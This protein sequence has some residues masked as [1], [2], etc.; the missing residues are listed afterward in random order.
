[1]RDRPLHATLLPTG[2]RLLALLADALDGG[3]AVLPLDPA[4]P[5]HRL[6]H[7]LDVLRP[8]RLVT[9]D[10]ARPLT[11]GVPVEGDTAVVIATSGS[12]GERKAVEL[13]A[14][15]LRFSGQAALRRLRAASDDRW[16]CCLPTHHIAGLQVLVRSLMLGREPVL[17]R[18]FGVDA[19][20][21]SGC[22]FV[23]LVPTMLRRILDAGGDVSAFR[24]ILLGGSSVPPGLVE[25]ARA[26]GATVVTTYGMSET[27][28][29]CVY[30]GVPLD[31]VAADVGPDERIRLA[32]PMLFTGYRGDAAAT[33][34]AREG[35]WLVTQDLGRMIDGR[36][37]VLGRSDDVI[38]TGGEKVYPDQVTRCL[39]R[40]PKV[41]DAA[42][43]GRPDREWGERVCAVVV[44]ADPANPPSVAELRDHVAEYSSPYCAPRDL[45]VVDAIPLLA[46]GKP[47]RAAL[48]RAV[49]G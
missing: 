13:S 4:A 18:R 24:A 41:R 39:A 22:A 44:P 25:E 47:D 35:R 38:T 46:S 6:R 34:A 11:G 31:G 28:G 17:H 2:P 10:G 8:A 27:C 19:V 40:H 14:A 45:A 3:P 1:M 48:R 21:D 15:A 32:G 33:A 43:V 12:T 9:D 36:L 23:S 42:V 37:E 26:A 7:L 5:K 49:G 29:G 20:L 30:D 16:L